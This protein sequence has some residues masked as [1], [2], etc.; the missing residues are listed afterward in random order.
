MDPFVSPG[1]IALLVI[2]VV[3][4]IVLA[5]TIKIVPQGY[6]YTVENFGR[7]TRTLTP[8]LSIIV[9]FVER[10][11]HKMNMMEQVLDIP[12]QE[13]ITR[14]NANDVKATMVVEAANSPITTIGDE[15]LGEQGIH[16]VPDI[17]ANAGGVTVS[18]FE[19]VQN[20]QVFTWSEEHVNSELEKYMLSAYQ[21]VHKVMD[22]RQ[23]NMRTAAFSIAIERVAKAERIRGGI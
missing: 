23:V 13:V 2:V 15:I 7:Y 3:A 8:G 17:L 10:I 21:A 4:L 1:L 18:Y 16:V 20:V 5:S 11:G 19:W 12:T 6:N 14:D 9:P 22:E